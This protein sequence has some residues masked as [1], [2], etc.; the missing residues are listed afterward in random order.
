[1][2]TPLPS[3]SGG[4]TL[5]PPESEGIEEMPAGNGQ[6]PVALSQ[7]AVPIGDLVDEFGA[8]S[9][10]LTDMRVARILVNEGRYRALERLGVRREDANMATLVMAMMLADSA[11]RRL[12]WVLGL[13]IHPTRYDALLAGGVA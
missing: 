6:T 9:L 10:L 2:Q 4:A 5:A 1:M 8:W 13:R 12:Q 11:A 7:G 3:A